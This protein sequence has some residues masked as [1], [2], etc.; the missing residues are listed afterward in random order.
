MIDVERTFERLIGRQPSDKE[1]Q[2]LY[3]VKGALDIQDNDALWLVLMALESYDTLYRRY[4]AIIDA[5]LKQSLEDQRATIAAIADAETKKALGAL[6]QAVCRTS[7]SVALRLT[8]A[9]WMLWSGLLMLAMVMFGSF[10]ALMGFVL[11]SGR[12]PY[13][14]SSREHASFAGLIFSTLARTPAGWIGAIAGIVLALAAAW[15]ARR[16]GE[17][18]GW[19][20]AAGCCVLV[21]LCLAFLWPSLQGA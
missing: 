12:L 20:I 11:G 9:S 2:S 18:G 1:I 19:R 10:C 13:W 6:A 21:A 16:D 14:A 8:Q 15:H 3:R 5:Q 17:S 4:P 7:A